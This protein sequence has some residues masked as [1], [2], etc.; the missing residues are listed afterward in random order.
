MDAIDRL[1]EAIKERVNGA[2]Q[3]QMRYV[4]CISVDWENKT[5][6]AKG[7]ADDSDYLD[8]ILG[9]GYIDIKPK[10]GTIC[11]IGIIDGQEVVTFLIN[12]E[13]VEL[14][15]ITGTK[16]VFNGG[17]NLGLAKIKELTDKLNVI[18]TA[19]NSLLSDYKS[20]NH[21]HP[22]GP[23]TS[24]VIPP[25]IRDLT[26]TEVSDIENKIITH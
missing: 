7:T 25:T 3:A 8:I 9:F 14:V 22:Q 26:K 21:Q 24:F 6:D 17:E 4:E 15:E 11:L 16:I 2:K 12:A 19:F 23:T 1:T 5:M 13:E 10:V 18:E 20:H